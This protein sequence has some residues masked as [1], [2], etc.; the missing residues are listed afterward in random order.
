MYIIV[1]EGTSAYEVYITAY[2]G[3]NEFFVK[4]CPFLTACNNS[5][6]LIMKIIIKVVVP[7]GNF[8]ECVPYVGIRKLYWRTM[9]VL[10]KWKGRQQ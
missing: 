5:R 1:F 9:C 10:V 2:S 6:T 4:K 8:S 7:D 3:T